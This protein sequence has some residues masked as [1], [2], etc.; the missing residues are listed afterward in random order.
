MTPEE[1]KAEILSKTAEYYRLVHA[2]K[3]DAPFVPGESRVNYILGA[4]DACRDY[5]G[6]DTVLLKHIVYRFDKLVSA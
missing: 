3:R 2:P 4:S 6:C 1:L 5:F